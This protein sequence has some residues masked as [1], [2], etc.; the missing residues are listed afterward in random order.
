MFIYYNRYCVDLDLFYGKVKFLWQGQ[1]SKLCLFFGG[2]GWA[3]SCFVPR[4]FRPGFVQSES[5]WPG[6]FGSESFWPLSSFGLFWWV[7]SA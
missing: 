1:I 3:L 5:F 2:G 7:V 6:S 4:S